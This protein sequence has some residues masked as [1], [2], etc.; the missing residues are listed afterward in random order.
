[1]VYSFNQPDA[2]STRQTQYYEVQGNR[3]IYHD[4]WLANTSPRGMPWN[5]AVTKGTD[6]STYTWELY[7]LNDDYS[8]SHDLAAELPEKLADM[9]ALFDAEA[10]KYNVYPIQDEGGM[11]RGMN[12]AR[13]TMKSLPRTEY[14]YWGRDVHLQFGVSPPIYFMP[15]SVEAEIEVPEQGANGVM[16]A[17]GSKFGGWS[18]YLDDGKPVAYASLLGLPIPG[19]QSRIAA[20][21]AVSPGKHTVLYEV[22]PDDEGPGATVTISID[23]DEVASGKVAERPKMPAGNGEALDTG[24]D[25][26]VAVSPDYSHEGVFTGELE[27]VSVRV[28]LPGV[29]GVMANVRD[30]AKHVVEAVKDAVSE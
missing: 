13:A 30:K 26:N 7:N 5:M 25:T 10:R 20:D 6:T 17:S 18:F 4:G 22:E 3:G 1:M 23:G 16:L 27:K 24:R 19:K 9:Q 29:A 21:T 28:Q 12:L 15:F 8:Q 11:Q 2:P 14:T